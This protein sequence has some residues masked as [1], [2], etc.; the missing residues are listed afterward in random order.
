[1]VPVIALAIGLWMLYQHASQ[2]GPEITLRIS[3][4]SGIEVGKT[5]IRYL[6]VKVGVVTEVGLSENYDHIVMK[7]QMD[8]NAQRM[9]RED[10]QFWVVK[11]RIGS[12]GVSGL[13]TILSGSYIEIKAGTSPARQFE[14]TVLDVPPV[15]PPDAKGLRLLLS[16]AKAG[17]LT[18]GDPVIYHGFTAGRVEKVSFDV[19]QKKALYQLFIYQPYDELVR[20]GT[21]FWINSGVDLQLNTEGFKLRFDSL[22]SLLVGGVSFGIPEGE[23]SGERV[24]KQLTQF[25][26]FNDQLAVKEGL[27]SQHVDYAMIFDESIR[28]L[29]PGAPV[30]FRGLRIG[31]VEKVPLFRSSLKEGINS[32]ALAVLIRVEPKRIFEKS[33]EIS[34]EELKKALRAEFKRGLRGTLKTG[35]LLT[36]A[37]Y[38]DLDYDSNEQPYTPEKLAG[39]DIFPSKPGGLAQV[40][41]QLM[42]LLDKFNSLPL[43]ETVVAMNRSLSALQKTLTSAEQT[44]DSV[45]NLLEQEGVQSLPAELEQSLNKIQQTLDGFAPNS[46]VYRNLDDSL[47]QLNKVMAELQP[48]LRQL[49]EKPNSLLFGED[50]V[51]DPVPV[52]GGK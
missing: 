52:K 5:E 39:Y 44:V 18:V 49:N 10:T 29:N 33:E 12:G 3:D 50:K 4:A 41:K 6:S 46:S 21:R 7:A 24:S 45:H 51:A 19:K 42:D 23:S 38:I 30:E 27:Y 15:A 37:L 2:T 17:K 48:V 35:S 14:F 34:K 22:E 11:P 43:N 31:S 40:Q 28:G 20:S 47:V 9:L 1:L 16:H 25:R 13:D 26:L 36:G 8:K 32:N